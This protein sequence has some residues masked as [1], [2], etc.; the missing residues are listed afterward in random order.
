MDKIQIDNQAATNWLTTLEQYT[1]LM[2][3]SLLSEER[4]IS[5]Q[6]VELPAGGV[7]PRRFRCSVKY[8]QC[9]NASHEACA[10]HPVGGV[11]I[12]GA[13]KRFRRNIARSRLG[14][15]SNTYQFSA[16]R[17]KYSL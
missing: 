14:S 16:L 5:I 17:Q 15:R 11:A 1:Y 7:M 12:E 13:L 3:S 6:L 10:E 4:Q 2:L 8:S 9:T